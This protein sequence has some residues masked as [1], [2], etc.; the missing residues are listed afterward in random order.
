MHLEILGRERVWKL[1]RLFQTGLGAL[2][3]IV[4]ALCL[5]AN[6]KTTVTLPPPAERK[7]DFEKDIQPILSARCYSCHGPDKQKADLRWDVKESA[8]KT[9]EHGPTIVPG[10]SAA[11]RVI[12][13]VSGA[14]PDSI[15]PPRGDRLTPEQIGLLRG[16]I[17]QGATW[18][19]TAAAAHKAADKRSHWAF[20][21]PVRSVVPSGDKKKWARNPIDAFVL[22]RLGKEKLAP[23]PE[24]D[25][26]TLIRRVTLDLTGLPP[27]PQEIDNFLADR[28]P[29]AYERLIERVLASPHYGEVWG[30]HWLDVARYADSN[31]YEKDRARSIWPYRDWVIRAFNQ[32]MPFNEFTIEQL[33]GDLLPNPTADQR[34]ATGFLRNAM[35][36]QEG[37]IEPE[38]FRVEALIDRVDTLGKAFLG[39]TINCCQ[40]HDHKFDPFTQQDYYRFYAFLNNDDEAFMEVPTRHEA[41]QRAQI[42]RKISE[43][44]D[45]AIAE[46][47]NL[48]DRMAAWE[49]GLSTPTTHWTVL[50]PTV[51]DCFATKFE[52]QEDLSLLG[53]GD[54][55]AGGVM[56]VWIDTDLTN[57]T[58]F[59]LEALT[60]AN[61]M[62][63]GPGELGKGSFL[64]REFTA[65]TYALENPTVTN[66]VKL[67]RAVADAEAPGFS[68]TNAIDGNTEKGGWTPTATAEH[69][70]ENHFAVF[71]CDQPLNLSHGTRLLITVHQSFEGD[72]KNHGLDADTK[73][74][75]HLL[76]S[77]RLSA[78]TDSVPLSSNPL[79]PEEQNILG[80]PVTQRTREQKHKL[81][82]IIRHS[83]PDCA[84][85][86]KEIDKLW[87]TWPFPATTMVLQERA[88]PRVTHVFK[89]GDRLRPTEAVQAGVPAFLN[90]LPSGAPLTRLGLAEWI[91][92]PANP[93]TARVIVNRIWQ[94]YFGQGLVTTPE[95]FG[96]RVDIPSHPEL[97]DW[98]A[99]EFMDPITPDCSGVRPQP[100]SIKHIHRLIVGSATYR[101]SSEVKPEIYARDQFDRWLE[102]APRVRVDGEIVQDIALSASGLLNPKIGGPSVY[103]PIPSSVGD[104]VYGGFN[105]PESKG[106]ERY[107]RGLYTFWKRSLPFPTLTAFDVPTAETACPRRVRSNTPLQALTTLNE[108]TFME[109]AQA[110]ALRVMKEAGPDDRARVR[111]AF[112]LCTGRQ[113]DPEETDKL[114][115]FWQEQYAH[116]E[117]DTADAVRVSSMEITNMPPEV[118]LHKVAAWAMVSRTILNLDETITRE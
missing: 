98:L 76:G 1:P 20:K 107:R 94:A 65:E 3:A 6:T 27:T 78:T 82:S 34:I 91:V 71:E 97:L 8:F 90:P 37:G 31:G 5:A 7:V 54:L 56:R 83:D 88:H 33:A 22:A 86:N 99:C 74:E 45:H 105:W 38:Q 92:N 55:N 36:N 13:L 30:R 32:D 64:I 63:G 19:A 10:N 77:F 114:L 16:W 35:L 89:R 48:D 118:N 4:P 23:S 61:L 49:K 52:K 109:A 9:G 101:Q 104:T 115:K 96:T 28:A 39:L 80:I 113:P 60:N 24:A 93:T 47:T 66:K 59:R 50:D 75:A 40:C 43:L 117:N 2:L 12:Q 14:E 26:V 100:W 70:N 112:R 106:D 17:D 102:R 51:W 79:T 53:G 21:A 72:D 116:F 103:P 87:A 11:S 25:R 57:V 42:L 85:L 18:P 111:Y 44:E 15:M 81:F 62:Y 46:S 73:L 108:K 67:R 110:M 95:D 29:G 68:V 58:G 69:R 41:E 84:A